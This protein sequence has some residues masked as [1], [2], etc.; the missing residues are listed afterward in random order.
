MG[1]INI[2]GIKPV[3]ELFH[4]IRVDVYPKKVKFED[5]S[6]WKENY[7]TL[8]SFAVMKKDSAKK[9]LSEFSIEEII[10]F[11]GDRPIMRLPDLAESIEKNG[12]RVPLIIL[13][14]GTLLDGNRRYFACGYLK[15]KAAEQEKDRPAVLDEIPVKVIKNKDINEKIR[16]KILA[17]ANFVEDHKVEW[18]LDVKAKVINDYFNECKK[19]RMAEENIYKEIFDVFSL[20]K[21]EVKEYVESVKLT[22]QFITRA[23]KE[24][25]NKLKEIV[26]AKFVYFWEF[27]NKAMSGARALE[28]GELKKVKSLF[29]K[30]MEDDHFKNLKQVEPMIQSVHD[31]EEWK[32]LEQSGGMLIDQIEASYKES[33]AVRSVEDKIRRFLR[34]LTRKPQKDDFGQGTLRVLKELKDKCIE[35]LNDHK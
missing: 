34:W 13:E 20:G 2:A 6:Y 27:R 11:M 8:L 15:L 23:I 18:P 12:V 30:M 16:Y 28:R 5:I 10:R 33:K 9:E 22:K 24:K 26:Q 25:E 19:R 31:K 35:I 32:L 4:N 14:D 17:E 3:E 7:R 21:Q 1:K 29:F